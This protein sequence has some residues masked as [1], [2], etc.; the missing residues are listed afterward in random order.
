MKFKNCVI[1]T[2][3]I[4]LNLPVL[5]PSS[6]VPLTLLGQWLQK[7]TGIPLKSSG[8]VFDYFHPILQLVFC[9][10]A[11][12]YSFHRLVGS[13]GMLNLVVV[14]FFRV[15]MNGFLYLHILVLIFRP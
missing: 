13:R 15:E 7:N 11:Y 6:S 8:I 4:L 2:L 3:F 5:T 10:S 9:C 12:G 1:L 14:L